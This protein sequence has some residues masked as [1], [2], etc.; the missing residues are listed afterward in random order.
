M[1]EKKMKDCG[2]ST[3]TKV[4]DVT[5]LIEEDFEKV[6]RI[7]LVAIDPEELPDLIKFGNHRV[8]T[9]AAQLARKLG[10][11]LF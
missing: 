5:D 11:D 1:T 7:D 6:A 4:D 9:K 10:I 3:S 8:R 2:G